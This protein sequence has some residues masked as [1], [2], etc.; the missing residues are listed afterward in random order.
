MKGR[1]GI[2]VLWRNSFT[3]SVK[4]TNH[5]S[6]I[7][8]IEIGHRKDNVLFVNLYMPYQCDVNVELYMQCLGNL[9]AILKEADTLKIAV[10]ED[11]KAAEITVFANKIT[12]W[13][14]HEAMVIPDM[15]FLGS[16]PEVHTFVTIAHNTTPWPVHIICST[17]MHNILSDVNVLNQRLCSDHLPLT[18]ALN[19]DPLD[20]SC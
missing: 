5:N 19:L 15:V 13:F 9:S 2:G 16:G 7:L 10:V 18:V 1:T 4:N 6:R 14:K 17:Q 3:K 20:I 11:F 8:S 12:E